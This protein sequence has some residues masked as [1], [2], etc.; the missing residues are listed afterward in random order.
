MKQFF[1]WFDPYDMK[2]MEAL[3]FYSRNGS[4][5]K[6]FVPEEFKYSASKSIGE[7]ANKVAMA[8][9]DHFELIVPLL[10]IRQL[11]KERK[12]KND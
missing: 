11:N 3:R 8:Y 6:G 10:K 12:E 9:V 4:W 7:I 5:P 2:H 1:E